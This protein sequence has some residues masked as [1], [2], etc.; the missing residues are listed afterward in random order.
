M[1]TEYEDLVTGDSVEIAP[2]DLEG[3]DEIAEPELVDAVD[4]MGDD[5]V[6]EAMDETPE[7]IGFV[8]TAVMRRGLQ[9]RRF[10][11][12]FRRKLRGM[13]RRK[14]RRLFRSWL[15]QRRRKR[16]RKVGKVAAIFR[17]PIKSAIGRAVVRRRARKAGMTSKQYMRARR[18]RR[19]ARR[20]ARRARRSL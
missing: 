15:R 19:R 12:K 6:I 18:E 2:P 13:S 3:Y 5:E 11:R 10:K 4:L 20:K 8:L 17:F 7:L 9:R 14:R 1:I 16:L